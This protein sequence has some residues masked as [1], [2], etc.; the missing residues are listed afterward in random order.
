[1]S[2]SRIAFGCLSTGIYTSKALK[3]EAVEIY[4]AGAMENET[5]ETQESDD[6]TIDVRSSTQVAAFLPFT[7]LPKSYTGRQVHIVLV[8]ET[9][10]AVDPYETESLPF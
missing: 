1:V 8:G 3:H 5:T 9:I 10:P 2:S 6:L 7:A 4:K